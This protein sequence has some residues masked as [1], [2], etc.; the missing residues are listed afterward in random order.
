MHIDLPL[1]EKN[2]A[3]TSHAESNY[4]SDAYVPDRGLWQKFLRLKVV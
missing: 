2:S 1:S 4:D 3:D